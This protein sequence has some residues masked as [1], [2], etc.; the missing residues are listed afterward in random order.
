MLS[1]GPLEYQPAISITSAE[2]GNE[3]LIIEPVYEFESETTFK[4]AKF[5]RAQVV[6]RPKVEPVVDAAP[7]PANPLTPDDAEYAPTSPS[8][9]DQ[10]LPEWP[11]VTH[12]THGR[13]VVVDAGEYNAT[14]KFDGDDS[15]RVVIVTELDAERRPPSPPHFDRLYF[16]GVGIPS[17]KRSSS[18]ALPSHIKPVDYN[19]ASPRYN[20]RSPSPTS[21]TSP[22][23]APTSPSYSPTSPSY[24][25]TSPSYPPTSPSYSP[26][27]PSY[28]PTSPS[29]APTSP[30]YAPTSP[31]YSPTSPSYAPTSPSYAP[32]SPS[33]SP[34]SPSYAPTS[35]SYNPRSSSPASPS[36]APTSPSYNPRP[37]SPASPSYNPRSPSPAPYSNFSP[38]SSTSPASNKR[39]LSAADDD[40]GDDAVVVAVVSLDERLAN[41]AKKA[42]LEGRYMDLTVD[43]AAGDSNDNPIIILE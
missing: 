2:P 39:K 24:A 17:R 22:S 13:G 12:P 20:P 40:D 37:P 32:T 8:V 23:Y 1:A 3:S 15:K 9:P 41:A 7:A 5:Q 14:V 16:G 34:T 18:P 6:V 26:T 4:L 35:P 42:K 33:Y 43:S 31:S 38:P 36:Y 30:S 27:S 10:P 19:P 11:V 29:Y 28:A 25:P 21:P